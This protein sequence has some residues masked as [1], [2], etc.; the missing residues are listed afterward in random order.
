MTDL[1]VFDKR[2]IEDAHILVQYVKIK[3]DISR[4]EKAIT[5]INQIIKNREEDIEKCNL[6][7]LF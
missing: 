1:S 4:Y 7:L 6:S 2:S 5:V 3:H